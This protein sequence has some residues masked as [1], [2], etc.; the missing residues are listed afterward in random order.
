[1]LILIALA[2]VLF[3]GMMFERDI[4]NKTM[5]ARYKLLEQAR[6]NEH[7]T[8]PRMID[9]TIEGEQLGDL[10]PYEVPFQADSSLR[11]GPKK[12]YLQ[13]GTMHMFPGGDDGVTGWKAGITGM[14]ILD[15]YE[16]TA[17]YAQQ[18]L[19]GVGSITG[20]ISGACP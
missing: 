11:Y 15:H 10:I 7:K 3:Q 17:G 8:R 6:Q 5:V 2:A 9:E 13:C 18:V 12:V 4:F 20:A 19:S 1:M 14:L 16:D